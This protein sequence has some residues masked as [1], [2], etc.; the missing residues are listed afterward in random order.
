MHQLTP[1]SNQLLRVLYIAII[2]QDYK[3]I[4]SADSDE[5][6]SE[7]FQLVSLISIIKKQ[8]GPSI[9]EKWKCRL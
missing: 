7:A 4:P 3:K 9:Y 5:P 8:Q 1:K 2:I 6:R